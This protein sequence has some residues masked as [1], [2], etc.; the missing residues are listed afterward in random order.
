[1]QSIFATM[2]NP[3]AS[4]TSQP[5]SAGWSNRILAAAVVGILFF[6]LYPFRFAFGTKVSQGGFPFFL[7]SSLK[8]GGPLDA[9][10]NILLFVPFGFG[11]TQKLFDKGMSRKAAFILTLAA[12]A[13]FSYLIEVV[14]FY[15]PARDS[16]WEDV[17]TNSIG[18]LVGAVFFEHAGKPIV[19]F[20]SRCEELLAKAL[21]FGR[22]AS[23]IS[24]YFGLW[25][26]ISIL[27]QKETRLS[28]WDPDCQL[29]VGNEA[30]GRLATPWKGEVFRL[31]FWD[32]PVPDEIARNLTA[33][34]SS[35]A[36]PAGLLADFDF[37][38]SA[39]LQDQK[40][41]LPAFSWT[42][43]PPVREA[44][45]AV[46]LDGKT[47]LTSKIPVS[48]LVQEIQGTN[49][50]AVRVR[51]SLADVNGSDRRIVSIS[52]SSGISNLTLRAENTELVFWFRNPLSVKRSL[53]AWYIPNVFVPNQTR[54]ILFSYDGSNLSAFIDGK[55]ESRFYRLGPGTGLAQVVRRVIPSELDGYKDIYYAIVFVP[56]G[57]LLGIA[58][59]RWTE[60]P[61]AAAALFLLGVCL[62]PA[63]VEY[64]LVSVSGRELSR[65]NVLLSLLLII[66]G[67]VWI[68]ADRRVYI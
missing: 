2:P 39:P 10:L 47:W 25:F 11:F 35:Q 32:R 19:V 8:I 15:I 21:T 5:S 12:G 53:L 26:A 28:N 66:A 63:I 62:P 41:F 49:Q 64:I 65:A 45:N 24:L 57:I 61:F 7:S 31:Q 34:D 59:R 68:N 16:G 22:A 18:A 42:P 9:F 50:F 36:E 55:K 44:P 40:K 14:Q 58:C 27:L 33:G 30:S 54:D 6:T 38:A 3:A 29:L 37:S 52:K 43:G 60:R 17:F 1:M 51:C 13:L 67:A 48:E 23:I 56:G 20:L 4:T 46:L